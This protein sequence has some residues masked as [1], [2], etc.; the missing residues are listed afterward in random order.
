L[1]AIVARA[2]RER[3]AVRVWTIQTADVRDILAAQGSYRACR[4]GIRPA[5]AKAYRWMARQMAGRVGP[6][7]SPESDPIWLWKAWRGA[8]R[9]RPDLRCTGHLPRGTRGVRLE[10]DLAPERVLLS[11]FELWHYVLNGWYLPVCK[12]DDERFDRA[13]H[14]LASLDPV[15]RRSRR[16]ALRREIQCSWDSV[17]DLEYADREASAAPGERSVQ[18]T[19]WEIRSSDLRDVDPFIAR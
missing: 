18:G 8:G 11:D 12:A 19:I 2:K 9:A 15:T 7:Q 6:P 3:D 5:W 10:L 1:R 13:A 17:F 16:I 4:Q 14:E